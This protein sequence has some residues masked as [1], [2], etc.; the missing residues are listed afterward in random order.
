MNRKSFKFF[1]KQIVKPILFL[2]DAELVH[3]FFTLIGRLLGSNSL[4]RNIT[5]KAFSYKN[6]KLTK[7]IKGI[8]FEDPIGLAAGFDYNG[9][10]VEIMKYVGFGFN[11]VGTVTYNEYA[12]NKPPRLARLPK[13]R[14][15]L[16]NKGFKS[17]G[18]AK[19]AARLNNPRLAN[20]TF[21]VSVG[22]SNIPQIN[23]VPKAIDDYT[24]TFKIL[25]TS[26]HIKYYELNISCPNT[27]MPESFGDPANFELLASRVQA[28]N[29][30]RPVFVKMPNELS[31]E[32]TRRLIEV[33]LRFGLD[34]YIFSNLVKNRLN[35]ALDRGE[36][37]KVKLLRG[38]FSGRPTFEGSNL[39]IREMR[40]SFGNKIVIVGCGG[41]FSSEDA[42]VKFEAGADLVQ[43][44]TGMI[45]EGPGLV[46]EI[47]ESLMQNDSKTP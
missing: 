44:I 43:L 45:F 28:L 26:P 14:S 11:T 19:V 23:T 29:L 1:Y 39:L 13:S 15:L 36:V 32:E 5:E 7:T 35:P 33:G 34:A 20:H 2:I 16:V 42:R 22:S 10:M 4:G 18:A 8:T 21:G 3:N 40:R 12:G 37:E 24:S 46:G 17:Q 6:P 41:V 47:C 27:S 31:L 30:S 38:N 9:Y 25:E